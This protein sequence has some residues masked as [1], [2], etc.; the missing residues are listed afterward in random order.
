MQEINNHI[1]IEP[2]IIK[3][4]VNEFIES[5]TSNK[6]L[7]NVLIGNLPLYAGVKDKTPIYIH[8]FIKNFYIQSA[9]RIVGGSDVIASSLANSIRSFGGEIITSQE[10]DKIICDSTHATAIQTKEGELITGKFFISNVHPEI[11]MEKIE[12]PLIRKIYKERIKHL[13][14]SIGNFTVYIK[15]KPDSVPYLNSTS[16]FMN[17]TTRRQITIILKM[18]IPYLCTNA[19]KR[20]DFRRS[21]ELSGYM[22]F[23]DV[24]EN[25]TVGKRGE[26]YLQFKE[27]KAERF[28]KKL[29]DSF[30]GIMNNIEYYET[31]TPLTYRDYTATKEGSMYGIL[32]DTNLPVQTYISQRT[33]IPNLFLTGQNINTHGILGV[34]IGS[35]ITCAEFIGLNNIIKDIH[36]H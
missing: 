18:P 36:I 22:K 16:I 19:I 13:E 3:A 6:E 15:F 17:L 21:A 28:I 25:T 1:I 5:I 12:S 20:D 11:T 32:R 30:P 14:N 2:N 4:T 9:Y 26:A 10:V 29:N 8:A 33:K 34:M 27:E 7:Q 35:I 31:S 23:D 24:R